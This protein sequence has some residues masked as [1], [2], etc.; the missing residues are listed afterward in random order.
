MSDPPK[1]RC[2]LKGVSNS[3]LLITLL[4]ASYH[5]L[6]LLLVKRANISD[7]SNK[8]IRLIPGTENILDLDTETN[9]TDQ[10]QGGV[11]SEQQV[12]LESSNS[13]LTHLTSPSLPP[14]TPTSSRSSTM[15][16]ESGDNNTPRVRYRSGPVPP[17]H[18][19]PVQ[20]IISD[21]I[22]E[23]ASSFHVSR[24]RCS[25]FGQSESVAERNRTGSIDS[26]T[27]EPQC[28]PPPVASPTDHARKIYI[29]MPSKSHTG[30]FDASSKSMST[31]ALR[32][33][34]SCLPLH[35]RGQ[36]AV[37][38]C[39]GI[40]RVPSADES[41]SAVPASPCHKPLFG[42]VMLPIYIYDC[43]LSSITTQLVN[44]YA[45]LFFLVWLSFTNFF[46]S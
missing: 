23:R 44:R 42:A 39:D 6:K 15:F 22:R 14:P 3:H 34:D 25:S 43:K 37:N 4:P 5:D 31:E 26:P 20:Q 1:W 45:I 29:S 12:S 17:T 11:T 30:I 21:S 7:A 36:G 13:S 28:D 24:D 2:F 40:C 19:Q 9:T 10:P 27:K 46:F 8:A 18:S 41:V 32:S 35:L 38:E 33:D 16:V